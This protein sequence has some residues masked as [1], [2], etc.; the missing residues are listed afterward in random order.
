VTFAGID[1]SEAPRDEIEFSGFEFGDNAN[2]SQ[3]KWLGRGPITE[4]FTRDHA[5]FTGATFGRGAKFTGAAFGDYADFTSA[6]FGR[7]AKFTGATFGLEADF[8]GAAFGWLANFTVAVFDPGT[9]FVGAA[10]GLEADFTGAAFGNGASFSGTHF[11]G[12]IA[13]IGQ[14]KEKSTRDIAIRMTRLK[15]EKRLDESWN[16]CGSSP[17]HFL[18]ISF[19]NARFDSVANFSG[20]SFEQ[21]G[22]GF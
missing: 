10:F 15:L 20:R 13:F 11:R 7:E 12:K 18:R 22:S 16:H 4:I 9:N 14:S 21:T 19:A 6:V 5:F 3:C 17:D 8:T 1:F 2:F